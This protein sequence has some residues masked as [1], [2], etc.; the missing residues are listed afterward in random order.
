M[1]S[2]TITVGL[3]LNPAVKSPQH[4]RIGDGPGG[5]GPF[6]QK[7]IRQPVVPKRNSARPVLQR[8]PLRAIPDPRR[9]PRPLP[10]LGLRRPF[11]PRALPSARL[12][13]IPDRTRR[14][15]RVSAPS[16]PLEPP[17]AVP[18]GA[19]RRRPCWSRPPPSLLESRLPPSLLEPPVAVP[20]LRRHPQP[21]LPR[22]PTRKSS[23]TGPRPS[24]CC[25]AVREEVTT[26][27]NNNMFGTS[28]SFSVGSM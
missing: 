18:A 5:K 20:D 23:A 26:D 21:L 19:A 25:A 28:L 9:E 12:G 17:A 10:T 11:L 7:G 24:Y 3:G 6:H 13:T 27:L 16:S 4:C 15:P 8:D 22:H 2:P 1:R 14:R